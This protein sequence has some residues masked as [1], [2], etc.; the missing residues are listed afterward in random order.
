MGA[1]FGSQG[2]LP[3][4]WSHPVLSPRDIHFGVETVM[5][6]DGTKYPEG[7]THIESHIVELSQWQFLQQ[8][9]PVLAFVV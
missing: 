5:V 8:V 4:A 1:S 2:V 9:A 7:F 3:F 6:L